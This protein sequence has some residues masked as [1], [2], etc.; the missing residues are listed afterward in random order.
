MPN[1]LA[2]LNGYGILD[3]STTD[4]SLRIYG[5]DPTNSTNQYNYRTFQILS[6][7][8]ES[9][10]KKAFRI[11][12][13]RDGKSYWY[14]LYGEHNL[15]VM[16]SV[17]YSSI[18]SITTSGSYKVTGTVGILLHLQWDINYAIQIF[19]RYSTYTKLQWRYKY[20]GSW[21]SWTII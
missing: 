12:D 11:R 16:E 13:Y 10:V 18:D 9:D 8:Y 20:S 17:A 4:A 14:V 3:G 7:S 21:G 1:G 5:G 2:F 19:N 15:P 6:Q